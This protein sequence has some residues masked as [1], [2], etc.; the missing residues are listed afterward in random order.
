MFIFIDLKLK[1]HFCELVYCGSWSSESG[2]IPETFSKY[3]VFNYNHRK[4]IK[5]WNRASSISRFLYAFLMVGSR[6]NIDYFRPQFG[7]GLKCE[8]RSL[9]KNWC[10]IAYSFELKWITLSIIILM[11]SFCQSFKLI[12]NAHKENNKGLSVHEQKC[13]S[14]A[15]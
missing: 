9:F 11:N 4:W 6:N 10:S 13:L 12:L 5:N 3:V 2:A 15:P 8:D 1:K 7:H 14:S